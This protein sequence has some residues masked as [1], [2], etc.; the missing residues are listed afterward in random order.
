MCN[1]LIIVTK[2]IQNKQFLK[3]KIKLSN[4]KGTL[5]LVVTLQCNNPRG[6]KKRE[7][8]KIFENLKYYTMNK[9]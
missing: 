5:T 1:Y 7:I 2:K 4:I 6:E 8:D 9:F 3:Q